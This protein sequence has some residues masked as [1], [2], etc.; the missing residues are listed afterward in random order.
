M[1]IRRLSID[2]LAAHAGRCFLQP[3]HVLRPR[4]RGRRRGALSS[5]V[6]PPWKSRSR[7]PGGTVSIECVG[8]V[9]CVGC[10]G[11]ERRRASAAL[12]IRPGALGRAYTPRRVDVH[13]ARLPAP[14][15]PQ[16]GFSRGEHAMGRAEIIGQIF[17]TR[18]AIC[19][20]RTL[21]PLVAAAGLTRLLPV[22][23]PIGNSPMRC[24]IPIRAYSASCDRGNIIHNSFAWN[25][26]GRENTEERG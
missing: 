13:A 24:L 23:R 3:A 21:H 10:V 2:T 9:G 15:R 26:H 7:L 14:L 18:A 19:T 25:L 12:T 11:C 17:V 8:R 22:R 16:P 4:G 5:S 1:P 20:L 6:R